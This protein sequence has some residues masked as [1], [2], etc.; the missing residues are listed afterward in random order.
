MNRISPIRVLIVD[1]H[2]VVRQGLISMLETVEDVRVVGDAANAAEAIRKAGE[3]KP[4]VILL[5]IRL[6]GA[7]GLDVCRILQLQLPES[8]VII[9]TSYMEDDYLF[10]AL[11]AGAWGYILKTDGYEELLEAITSVADGRRLLSAPFIDKLVTR[12]SELMREMARAGSG[13]D[14]RELDILELVAKGMTNKEISENLHW[15]EV[16][17]KRKMQIIFDKLEVQDRTS[18]A[19]EAIRRGL[20]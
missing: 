16:S 5:D 3:L 17:I 19:V 9:L 1:D 8:R 10:M 6:P 4:E 13:F 18:A 20:I 14:H 7:S 12:F 11:Q 15:S 2:K